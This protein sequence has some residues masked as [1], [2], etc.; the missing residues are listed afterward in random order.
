MNSTA[1]RIGMPLIGHAPDNLGLQAVLDNHQDLAH[2][3]ILVALYFVPKR[4]V[5]KF[6]LPSL[7]AFGFV[8]LTTLEIVAVTV[9]F[10]L[11]GRP[12]PFTSQW[13]TA[14]LLAALCLLFVLLWPT[15]GLLSS[16]ASFLIL[17]SIIS[18]LIL[19]FSFAACVR[20]WRGWSNPSAPLWVKLSA[21]ILAAASL[22]F[23]LSIGIW[24]PIAWRSSQ[25]NLT[26]LAEKFHDAGIWVEPTLDVL[27]NFN[28]MNDGQGAELLADPVSATSPGI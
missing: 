18:V 19:A 8:L 22:A 5:A 28:L 20:T 10:R 24:L 6:L 27:H 4:V 14:V 2:S 9:G 26:T 25:P 1:R 15:L 16:S 23:T 17:L 11:S 13:K 12:S 3:G 21:T 7:L